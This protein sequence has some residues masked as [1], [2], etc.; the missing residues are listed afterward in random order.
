MNNLTLMDLNTFIS[1][2]FNVVAIGVSVYIAYLKADE[3]LG[4]IL[5]RDYQGL[6]TLPQAEALADLYIAEMRR[7]IRINVDEFCDNRLAKILEDPD[8]SS[9]QL[10]LKDAAIGRFSRLRRNVA[11][12]FTSFRIT[13]TTTFDHF[14]EDVDRSG[15]EKATA[16]IA[17]TIVRYIESDKKPH[18]SAL[19][20][21]LSAIANE[22]N[23]TGLVL[24][25][26]KLRATYRGMN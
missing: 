20:E 15:V 4:K 16:Q 23:Q 10:R 25:K 11:H 9:V 13:P 7:E 18:I 8:A 14:V 1:I 6:M 5:S 3:K 26:E 12:Q 22:A 2:M 19:K 24:I 21:Q 17:A